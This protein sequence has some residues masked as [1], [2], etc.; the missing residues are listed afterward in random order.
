MEDEL[1]AAGRYARLE[2]RG[3]VTGLPRV[4]TI[5]FVEEADG[6]LLIAARPGAHWAENLFEDPRCRVTVGEQSWD[7]IAE[8]LDGPD[9]GLV[10]REQIL[11]YGTPA[12]ALGHGLAFRLRS[13]AP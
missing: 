12:E 2:T 6:S 3:R 13:I 4:V 11:R 5:G 10:I 7:A 9:F 8:V 1:V